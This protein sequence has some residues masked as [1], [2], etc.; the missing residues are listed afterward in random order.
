[1][2]SLSGLFKI[3]SLVLSTI[4][5]VYSVTNLRINFI[6]II[7]II[8]LGLEM[9]YLIFN[10]I[11]KYLFHFLYKPNFIKTIIFKEGI[12]ETFIRS[13]GFER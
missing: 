6:Y 11:Y 2:K 12:D 8:I 1:M 3:Y 4:L 9:S 5:L 10:S 13:N 7:I